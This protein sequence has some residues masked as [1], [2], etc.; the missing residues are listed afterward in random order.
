MLKMQFVALGYCKQERPRRCRIPATSEV[1]TAE[2]SRQH[3][4]LRMEEE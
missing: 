2:P 4:C 3:L 1:Q